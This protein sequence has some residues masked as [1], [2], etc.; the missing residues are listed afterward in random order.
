MATRTVLEDRSDREKRVERLTRG[1][2]RTCAALTVLITIGIVIAL[3]KDAIVFF[4]DPMVE[5]FDFLFGTEWKPTQ[6]T[7]DGEY[8]FG[9]LPLLS[10]TIV[11][12]VLSAIIALPVG[13]AAAIYLSEYAPETVRSVLK[14]A[15]EILAGVPTIVYGYFALVY[16]TPFLQW[17]GLPVS[18]FNALSASIVV[19]VMI[20]PLVS[21]ISEDA[22][23]A[24]PDSL[25]NAGYGLGST[26]FD[27]STKIVVPA[28]LSGVFSSYVLA[29]SRAIGETM[30][31]TVA[32]G[33]TPRLLSITNL[34]QNIFRSSETITAAMVNVAQAEGGGGT[35][36]FYS[37]FALG[38]VLFAITFTF[39][40]AA[41]HLRRSLREEY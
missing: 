17:I 23:S 14:P 32:A 1:L 41:D 36:A 15:L 4:S 37:M 39:N 34:D 22:L 20:I 19:A 5:G 31:V 25:R 33:Q 11:I 16:I 26:K 21:S 18:T 2:F 13:L 28:A 7:G 35:P 24:V 8:K 12:T 30:A 9:I 10:G 40:V 38:L 6:L 3:V 29:L 27:V